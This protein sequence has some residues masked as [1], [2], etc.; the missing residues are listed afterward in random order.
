[1][2]YLKA[3]TFSYDDSY[4]A[5]V[6]LSKIF[7]KYGLKATFNVI[8][9]HTT[10]DVYKEKKGVKIRHLNVEDMGDTYEGHEIA[11]HTIHHPRLA[12]MSYE[13]AEKEIVESTKLAE[14]MYNTKITGFA[15][16]F[17]SWSDETVDILR[18]HNFLYARAGYSTHS[19][20]LQDNLL[21]FN[22]TCHHNDEKLFELAEEF[23]NMECDELKIFYVWGHAYEFEVDNNWERIEKFCQIISGHNDIFYGT[24]K[25]VFELQ[26]KKQAENR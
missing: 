11:S 7:K 6:R 25:E 23:I 26:K 21:A 15:Y 2:E 14:E 8:P 16:P 24:N 13:E 1:M 17:C 12:D 9:K 10:P 20:D 4:T 19:F 18:K 22:P 3:V 5:D